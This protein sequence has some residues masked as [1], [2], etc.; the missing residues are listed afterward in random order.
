MD[1]IRGDFYYIPNR[2]IIRV[3]FPVDQWFVVERNVVS[4]YYPKSGRAFELESDQAVALPLITG[5]MAASRPDLGLGNMGYSVVDQR[6]ERDT[7]MTEW[8]SSSPKL[9][10]FELF[11]VGE[12]LVACRYTDPSGISS[13]YT[14]YGN[15]MKVAGL[16]VPTLMVTHLQTDVVQSSEF[17]ALDSVLFNATV[18][19]E[20]MYFQ[21][22]AHASLE[23][24]KW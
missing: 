8:S 16:Q 17:V 15:H 14:Q 22:P 6:F 2:V 24:K 11:H 13:A 10:K 1:S 19:N 7:I 23:K 3:Y 4:I 21:I 20:I 9:G 12:R 5:L 18:P